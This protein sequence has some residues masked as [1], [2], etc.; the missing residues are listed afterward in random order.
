MKTTF[1]GIDADIDESLEEY[2]LVIGK[3]KDCTD[4]D[5]WFCIYKI[6]EDAYGRG[7]I[8]DSELDAL[9]NGNDWADLKSIEGF[10]NYT[11][12]LKEDWI[13]MPFID[14]LYDLIQYY[15]HENI[16]GTEYSPVSKQIVLGWIF[17]ANGH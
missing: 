4:A 9:I 14:K 15:G 2:G 17:P 8:K 3:N 10:L 6:A 5:E 1:M 16:M 12:Q 11:G 13:E 7:Y